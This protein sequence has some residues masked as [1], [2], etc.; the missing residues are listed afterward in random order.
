R[1]PG[2]AHGE[3][4]LAANVDQVVVVF[5]VAKPEP[6]PRMLDRFL[7]IAEANGLAA[8]VVINKVDLAGEQAARERFEDYARAGYAM[9]FTRAKQGAGLAA[10]RA[11]LGGS[12][13]VFTGPSGVGKSSLLNALFPGLGL[14]VGEVSESVNKGRHTTVGARMIPLPGPDGGFV[15]D[16]PGL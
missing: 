12:V 4:I 14:R 5:S 9:H 13:S 1:A 2:G 8:R 16:T 15:V 7:V 11:A 6:H 10:V 3:R